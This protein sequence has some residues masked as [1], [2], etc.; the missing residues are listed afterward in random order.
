[1]EPDRK[2]ELRSQL[3]TAIGPPWVKKEKENF[4][5]MIYLVNLFNNTL[6]TVDS[7]KDKPSPAYKEFLKARNLHWM[8]WMES[9]NLETMYALVDACSDAEAI[10]MRREI[11][12]YLKTVH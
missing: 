6:S 4:Q 11:R 9:K 7:T 5:L 10:Q 1:M 2:L 3:E 8:D 12:T